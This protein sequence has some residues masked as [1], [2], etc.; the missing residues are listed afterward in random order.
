MIRW[1]T[2]NELEYVK[3]EIQTD[4]ILHNKKYKLNGKYHHHH[5]EGWSVINSDDFISYAYQIKLPDTLV[6]MHLLIIINKAQWPM[7]VIHSTWTAHKIN[8]VQNIAM[9]LIIN[10]AQWR[11]MKP[12]NIQ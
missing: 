7:F 8:V 12:M 5:L 3:G 11:A 6:V 4:T 10:K 2:V 1:L 9:D